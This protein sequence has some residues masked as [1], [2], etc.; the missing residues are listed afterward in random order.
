MVGWTVVLKAAWMD[1]Q[2]VGLK[3]G[4]RVALKVLL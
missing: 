3:V 4:L 1:E 2:K